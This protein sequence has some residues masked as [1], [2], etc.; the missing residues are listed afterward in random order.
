MFVFSLTKSG[1]GVRQVHGKDHA[2]KAIQQQKQV[3]INE[4]ETA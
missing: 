3:I 2:H 1:F 4:A